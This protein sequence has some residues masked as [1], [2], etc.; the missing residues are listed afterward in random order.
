MN[1]AKAEEERHIEIKEL[2]LNIFIHVMIA[3]NHAQQYVQGMI[4]IK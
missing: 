3:M 1:F 2:F 4:L